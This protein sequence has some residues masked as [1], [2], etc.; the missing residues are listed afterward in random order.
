MG[1]PSYFFKLAVI[2][3]VC[4]FCSPAII[5]FGLASRTRKTATVEGPRGEGWSMTSFLQESKVNK[6]KAKET[7]MKRILLVVL[8][9]VTFSLLLSR[10]SLAFCTKGL[11]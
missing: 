9:L 8:I 1:V 6:S 10:N 2:S 4:R 7:V 11:I 5:T 3:V